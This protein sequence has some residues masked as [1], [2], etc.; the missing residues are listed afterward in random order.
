MDND[1]DD[2]T[3]IVTLD[4]ASWRP[5]VDP[6]AVERYAR[7]LE[8]GSVLVLPRLAFSLAPDETRFLDVRWSDGKAKNISLDGDSIKGARGSADEL[9]ALRR[10][11]ARFAADATALVAAL[12]PRYAPHLTRAR[13]S[14]RPHG[15]TGRPVSWRK[16][17]TRLHVDAFPSRPNHGERIL[18]V[19]CNVNPNG[20][21]RVWRVGETF[22]T[23]ARRLLPR[24]RAM[25][26]GE[27]AT[28]AALRVTKQPRSQYDHLMLG[29][30][31]RA[32]ADL[33]YQRESAQREVRFAPGTTWI[34]YSDQ[35]MHAAAAGQYMLEQTT[36]LPLAALYEPERSPLAVLER[37]AGRQLVRRIAAGA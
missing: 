25:Y 3:P 28:L 27:A 2:V 34:C 24:I 10:M 9:A 17:D 6:A 22:E 33:D 13:T 4:I 18:R 29:L 36:H 7:A 20:E 1:S 35:V 11:V 21:D 16:D 5:V 19:F 12:F 23:M 14:Y 31:D 32:K 8:A 37:L 30:H 15:A 26:A